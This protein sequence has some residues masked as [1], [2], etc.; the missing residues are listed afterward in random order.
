MTF[1]EEIFINIAFSL[2]TAFLNLGLSFIMVEI[3]MAVIYWLAVFIIIMTFVYFAIYGERRV[4][5]F[6][7]RRLGPNSVGP[8]GLLQSLADGLKLV[9]KELIMPANADKWIFK[10]APVLMVLTAF[11]VF[12]V[13]PYG[14]HLIPADLNLGVFYF[15]AISSA[16][17]I[18]LFMAGWGS[19]NKFSLLGGMRTIAQMISYEIP[20][21]L[22]ILGV[23]MLVGTLQISEIVA[24]QSRVWFVFLQPLAFIIFMIAGLAETHRVPF[25]LAEAESEIVAGIHT[26]YSGIRW[27]FIPLAEYAHLLAISAMAVTLFLGGWHGPTILPSYFWFFGKTL[28]LVFF[29]MW[30]RWTFPRIRVDHLMS[31]GWKVLLPLSLLNIFLTGIGIGVSIFIFN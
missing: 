5:G 26:E 16:S 1:L 6:I 22:S 29:F 18:P 8:Q 23:V 9:G 2:R 20:L 3:A 13:F 30:I 21:V 10:L 12:A 14:K 15:I 7:Q 31:F 4:A 24:A 19:G 17:V 25:D 11:L 28:L 27:A